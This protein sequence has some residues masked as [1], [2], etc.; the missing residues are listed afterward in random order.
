MA[1]A[2]FKS[3]VRVREL[4]EEVASTWAPSIQMAV[5]STP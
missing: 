4:L 5:F 2:R 1:I 3:F